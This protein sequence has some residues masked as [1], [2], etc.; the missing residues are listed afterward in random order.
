MENFQS[1]AMFIGRMEE[2]GSL[3][4]E[5][6]RYHSVY[7]K[8]T[9]PCLFSKGIHFEGI[10]VENQHFN[11]APSH[12]SLFNHFIIHFQVIARCCTNTFSKFLDPENEVLGR[13]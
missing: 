2:D 12:Y 4:E 1:S 8:E 7:S 6:R 10:L 5:S 11:E 9:S 3:G 13:F